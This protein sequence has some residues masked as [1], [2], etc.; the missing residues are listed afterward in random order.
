MPLIERAVD[1]VG[2]AV[3]ALAAQAP[4]RAAPAAPAKR[5]RDEPAAP[6]TRSRKRAREAPGGGDDAE[7]TYRKAMRPLQYD[8]ADE[9]A[10]ATWRLAAP[11]AA[12]SHPAFARRLAQEHVDISQSLPLNASSS[13]WCRA[14]PSRMDALRVA[15]AAPEGTPY[16]G[17]LFIF[18]VRF[19][20]TYPSGPPSVQ[21]LTTGR[22]TV[23]FNPNLYECGKVCLSLLG[24]WEGRAGETWNERTST[25]LQV[26]VSIQ[27]LIFVPDPYYNEP[28]YEQ[29]MGTPAGDAKSDQYRAN[30]KQNTVKWAMLDALKNPDPSFKDVAEKHFKLRADTILRDLDVALAEAKAKA[31]KPPPP[32]RQPAAGAPASGGPPPAGDNRFWQLHAKAFE[33]QRAELGDLLAALPPV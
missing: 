23:R 11:S 16:S 24:T 13:A 31:A 7:A 29:Q 21:L 28:G 32:P 14:H 22:G 30:V 8:E 9:A 2:A 3:R 19:P 15:I 26:L 20:P 5:P 4:R 6:A 27:A 12:R 25:L 18:D 17:G 10:A 33:A 1:D